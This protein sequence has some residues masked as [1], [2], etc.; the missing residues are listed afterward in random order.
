MPILMVVA[1]TP[2]ALRIWSTW[3]PPS[4]GEGPPVGTV[5]RPLVPAPAVPPPVEPDVD[6][7]LPPRELGDEGPLTTAP[8]VPPSSGLPG[9]AATSERCCTVLPHAVSVANTAAAA[10]AGRSFTVAPIEMTFGPAPGSR[11]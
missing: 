1:V 9:C 4:M 8:V 5:G 2:G 11:G 6:P 7:E 3:L 10:R